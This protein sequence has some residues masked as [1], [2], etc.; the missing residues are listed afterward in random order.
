MPSLIKADG[1][2]VETIWRAM[3]VDVA[4][5]RAVL[6]IQSDVTGKPF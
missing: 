3:P 1:P 2:N 4:M 6:A 5:P